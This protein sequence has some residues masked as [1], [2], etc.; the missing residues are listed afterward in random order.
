M[1]DQAAQEFVANQAVFGKTLLLGL[2]LHSY[3]SSS[4]G[5]PIYQVCDAVGL[6]F[7]TLY[8]SRL[9]RFFA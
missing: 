6:V 8:P 2:S 5:E 1:Q 3:Q 9:D 7:D 4:S